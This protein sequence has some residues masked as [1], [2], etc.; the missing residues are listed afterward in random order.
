[1]HAKFETD[2]HGGLCIFLGTKHV[3]ELQ[4]AATLKSTNTDGELVNLT[5]T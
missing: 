1:M 2:F 4:G 5:A 3:T